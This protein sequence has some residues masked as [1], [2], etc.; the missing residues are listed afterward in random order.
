MTFSPRLKKFLQIF[1]FLIIVVLLGWLIWRFF[2]RSLSVSEPVPSSV[3]TSGVGNLPGAGEGNVNV[4]SDGDTQLPGGGGAPTGS[5]VS[6]SALGGLTKAQALSN[7]P[8]LAV[9]LAGDRTGVQY[10][11]QKDGY[12]YKLDSSGNPTKL[13]DQVFHNVSTVTWAPDKTKAIMQ[14]PDGSQ[15]LYDFSANKQTSIPKHWQDFSFSP[16]S[17]A[18]VSKSLGTDPGNRYL[19]VSKDDGSQAQAVEEIGT[20]GK[21]IYPSWSPNNQVVA[22]WTK[23]LDFD[24]QE[25]F[26]LGLNKE[27][28]KS[29]IIEGRGF[30]SQWS[31]TGNELLY[32]V[33]NSGNAM[34]PRLWIVGASGDNIG[35]NRTDLSINTWS[36][37]CTFSGETTLYCAV[38]ENLPE[39][40]GLFPELADRTKDDLY[41]IDLISG[42]TKL[43]AVPDGSYNISQVMVSDNQKFLYFTDKQS[44]KIYKINLQ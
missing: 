28:F 19:I 29:T 43:V 6:D 9:T 32:S 17:S 41:Q 7:D 33:Y 2:F 11:N 26:F 42:Q 5:E 40:A 13:S 34:N 31:P 10:Y 44:G 12:F 16:D 38:P 22:L 27:N 4:K 23:G 8:G 1:I 21:N 18:L 36:N 37:K 30:Q 20:N 25:V 24:R 35:Q 14:Y 3:N 39:G 15:I